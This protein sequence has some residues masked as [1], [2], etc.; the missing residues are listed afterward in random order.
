MQEFTQIAWSQ[1][2]SLPLPVS[3]FHV[4]NFLYQYIFHVHNSKSSTNIFHVETQN[5]WNATAVNQVRHWDKSCWNR[6]KE[7]KKN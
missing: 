3:I 5:V 4:H 7:G 1:T 2:K 6:T